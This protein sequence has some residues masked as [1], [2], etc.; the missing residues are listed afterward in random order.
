MTKEIQFRVLGFNY[1]EK[2]ARGK[3]GLELLF[4]FYMKRGTKLALLKGE[5]RT[6]FIATS[7]N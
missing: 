5:K 3:S 1:R 2:E 4:D 7:P 6:G